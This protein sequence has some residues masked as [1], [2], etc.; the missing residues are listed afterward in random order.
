VCGG[1]AQDGRDVVF[2][3]ALRDQRGALVGGTALVQGT[4]RVVLVVSGPQYRAAE[5]GGEVGVGVGFC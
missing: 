1:I 4:R 3:G 5:V 2:V